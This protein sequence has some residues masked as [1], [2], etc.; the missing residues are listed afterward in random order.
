MM[1]Q[2]V[3][4]ANIIRENWLLG[5]P[6]VSIVRKFIDLDKCKLFVPDVVR[7]EINKLFR[8]EVK[9]HIRAI[10]KLNK[11]NIV[12]GT[13][14]AIPEVGQF[15]QDYEQKL[16]ERLQEL[17]SEGIQ[18][19]H[20]THEQVLARI[21][22]SRKPFRGSDKGYKDTLIWEGIMSIATQESTT[23]FITHN[24][25]DF[26]EGKDST[27]LH[28]DLFKDV[29]DKGLPEDSV[30]VCSSIKQFVDVHLSPYLEKLAGEV[31]DGLKSGQYGG[32]NIGDWFKENRDSVITAVGK[33][34]E[35]IFSHEYEFED[36]SISYIED[37][38]RIEVEEA[39]DIENEQVYF[40][41]TLFADTTFDFYIYK[42]DLFILED[43]YPLLDV[44]NFDWNEHYAW[45]QMTLLVPI[46]ISIVFDVLH[47]SVKEF[48]VNDF[49]EIFGWCSTCGAVIISDASEEC[50]KCGKSFGE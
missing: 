6:S 49:D 44:Q 10:S 35:T 27:R 4:D 50:Y 32:F 17:R 41:V 18:Y 38:E 7:L 25:R 21:N 15:C 5:G 29:R 47:Q 1:W 16:N 20:V 2:V 43:R 39:F 23:C 24:Y 46:K 36:A 34:A 9:S 8:E 45:A 26:C 28:S 13:D 19:D 40:D 30:L 14:I 12:E 3:L 22:Q 42:S 33:D 48:E 11:L 37:P 31:L